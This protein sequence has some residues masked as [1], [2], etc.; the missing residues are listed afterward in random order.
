[1]AEG[2]RLILAQAITYEYDDRALDVSTD[3][4]GKWL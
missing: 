1:M 2:R 4:A 3:A